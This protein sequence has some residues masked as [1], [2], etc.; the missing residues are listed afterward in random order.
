MVAIVGR[1]T[2]RAALQAESIFRRLFDHWSANGF[3]PANMRSSRN[4]RGAR[5][6]REAGDTC[7]E[8]KQHAEREDGPRAHWTKWSPSVLTSAG[9]SGS[10]HL[11][12]LQAGL[13]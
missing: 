4:F 3:R 11:L 10:G 1:R 6:K 13:K 5:P 8:G 7:T 2:A 9:N 12:L